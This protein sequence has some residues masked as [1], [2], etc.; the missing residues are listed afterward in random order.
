VENPE[1]RVCFTFVVHR[2]SVGATGLAWVIVDRF[3]EGDAAEV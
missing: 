3:A 1:G 2:R